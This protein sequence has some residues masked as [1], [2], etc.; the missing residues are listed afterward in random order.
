MAL[1]LVGIARDASAA[2][3]EPHAP[4]ARDPASAPDQAKT[5]RL[6]V[7]DIDDDDAG[8]DA[9]VDQARTTLGHDDIVLERAQLAGEL[10]LPTLQDL[11]TARDASAAFWFRHD[12]PNRWDV[13]LVD[14]KGDAYRRE[15]PIDPAS[16]EATV[17]A[18]W[19]IVDGSSRAI[20]AGEQVAMVKVDLPEPEPEPQPQPQPQ[21]QPEPPPED[22]TKPDPPPPPPSRAH[23]RLGVGYLGEGFADQA[24][25]QSGVSIFGG[26][27]LGRW[28][29]LGL[30]ANALL[31]NRPDPVTY[32]I[33][34]LGYGGVHFGV[35]AR[36]DFGVRAGLGAELIG[37]DGA[38]RPG[39]RTLG[40]AGL[41]GSLEIG[42]VER[43]A[44]R[45]ALGGTMPLNP[46][47]FVECESPN[48][49]CEGDAR[50]I[51]LQP[52]P[53]RIRALA[54]FVLRL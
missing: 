13:Y 20:A 46:V 27:D 12:D 53:A 1:V 22:E 52:W 26:V 18:V 2:P 45:L 28:L 24:P 17:E 50:R 54:G 38:S 41:D 4:P 8:I 42:I 32:R 6:L 15:V 33:Q 11:L 48:A 21:P 49:A 16:P 3:A 40:L 5:T 47:T 37:Y 44:F 31:S 51:V 14:R 43:L 23:G 34:V 9:A 25:W 10:A 39:L 35:G 19:L 7:L 30:D 36:L 29:R